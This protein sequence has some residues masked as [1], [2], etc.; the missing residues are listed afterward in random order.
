MID[1][2]AKIPSGVLRGNLNQYGD[3][4][5]CINVDDGDG[6]TGKYCLA[7][8]ELKRPVFGKYINAYY[9]IQ[10]NLTDVSDRL[11]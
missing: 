6:L 7:A 5:E 8:A 1:S 11:N 9:Q 3:F 4:D 10:N 2:S